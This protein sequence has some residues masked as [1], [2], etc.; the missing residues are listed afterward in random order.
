DQPERAVRLFAKMRQRRIQPDIRTYEHLFSLVGTVNAPYEK[1]NMLSQVDTMKRIN[2]IESDMAKNDV[3]HS[4][5]SMRNLLRALGAE[6]MTRELLYY[7]NVA[8]Q[9]FRQNNTYLGPPIYNTVLFS[10]VAAG[11]IQ[12]AIEIFKYIKSYG[13][14]PNIATY[15]I[16]IDSCSTIKC[17]KSACAFVSMMIRDGFYPG[18]VTYTALIKILLDH[19]NFDEAL[20]LLDQA[21][22]EGHERDELFYNTILHKARDEV[23]ID[24][25]EFII[26]LMHR[27]KVQPDPSTCFYV[28][29]TYVV[30]GFHHTAVEA[31]QVMSMWMISDEDCTLEEKKSQYEDNFVLSEDSEAESRIIQFLNSEE[32]LMAALLNLRW[33]AMLGFPISWSPNQ[34]QW[35]RRLTIHF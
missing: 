1:G 8:E 7:F 18:K 25:M 15:T 31:L 19:A 26:K 14:H 10:L 35:A 23:R 11:E 16:M 9:L 4:F 21:S 6:G 3:Q 28:F 27:D 32:H 24:I 33:C 2:A 34:S 20:N 29:S 17:F 22:L 30:S 12:T 5:N 13:F